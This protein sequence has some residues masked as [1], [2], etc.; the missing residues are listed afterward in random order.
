M[1]ILRIKMLRSHA[2]SPDG[3][4][5]QNYLEG[6]SYDVPQELA[7]IFVFE[8]ETAEIVKPLEEAEIATAV[9][10]EPEPENQARASSGNRRPRG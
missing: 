2:G 4:T 7:K 6:E 3:V 5:V 10:P 8:L 1:K 9:E